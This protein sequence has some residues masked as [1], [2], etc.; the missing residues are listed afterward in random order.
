MD[1]TDFSSNR[2]VIA[3]ILRDCVQTFDQISLSQISIVSGHL[4]VNCTYNVV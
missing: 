4:S 2:V 1:L 3:D